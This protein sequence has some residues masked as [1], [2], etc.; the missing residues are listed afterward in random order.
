VP[1][2]ENHVKIEITIEDD[3]LPWGPKNNKS[4]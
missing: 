4:S 2:I 1:K 3:Y